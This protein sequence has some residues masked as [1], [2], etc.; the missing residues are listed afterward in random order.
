MNESDVEKTETLLIQLSSESL[1]GWDHSGDGPLA[2]LIKHLL[3]SSLFTEVDLQRGVKVI[4][5]LMSHIKGQRLCFI[6]ALP[7][8]L[9]LPPSPL[10]YSGH[11]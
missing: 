8:D 1:S 6:Q 2:R 3:L 10:V 4:L 5:V 9:P 7:G 11:S